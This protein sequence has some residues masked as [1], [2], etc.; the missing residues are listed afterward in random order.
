MDHAQ[1]AI[2]EWGIIEKE[3]DGGSFDEVYEESAII[4]MLELTK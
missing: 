4:R 3:F 1:N 2:D